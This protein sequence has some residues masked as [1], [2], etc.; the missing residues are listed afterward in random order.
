VALIAF[1]KP[2]LGIKHVSCVVAMLPSRAQVASEPRGKDHFPTLCAGSP[3]SSCVSYRTVC[4]HYEGGRGATI[5]CRTPGSSLERNTHPSIFVLH[6]TPPLPFQRE[7]SC[8]L[9]SSLSSLKIPPPGPTRFRK[10][11]A[12]SAP[13]ALDGFG[14]WAMP[15]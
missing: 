14:F 1:V 2:S 15:L 5:P 10:R 11:L 3:I 4:R 13:I 6:T 8:L 7:S 9:R 12:F